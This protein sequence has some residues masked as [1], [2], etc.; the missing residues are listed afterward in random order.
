VISPR[1]SLRN[2]HLLGMLLALP[3]VLAATGSEASFAERSGRGHYAIRALGHLPG[4]EQHV[5]ALALN[6]TGTVVGYQ[7]FPPFDAHAVVWRGDR[8][9]DLSDQLPDPEASSAS[10]VN[11]STQIAG[12]AA[13]YGFL[14]TGRERTLISD[15]YVVRGLNASG[16]V[17]G[18]GEHDVGTA[19]YVW[20]DGVSHDLCPVA[21]CGGS[22]E[23]INDL[24][25]VV[26]TGWVEI[27]DGTEPF[28]W[29]DGVWEELGTLGGCGG[30]ALGVNNL[31]QVVGWADTVDCTGIH[32]F[33]WE[34]GE[35]T[36]LGTIPCCNTS[37][38]TAINDDGV[39]VGYGGY[40]GVESDAFIYRDG[41]MI[42]LDRLL[43]P[44]AGW[45]LINAMDINETGQIV[46]SGFYRG[47][48]NAFVMTPTEH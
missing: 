36:D 25:H 9:Y 6:N 39:I 40:S 34:N 26:G 37:V 5:Q 17:V 30:L 22:G 12:D 29:R 1:V 15:P 16:A 47:R 3:V 38:A 21:D 2:P 19:P 8:V 31:D 42:P 4:G 32:A 14:F 11:D 27:E 33:R 44:G 18:W 28:L 46:G 10:G 13:V 41:R 20:E 48:F 24:G 43:P 23:D 35:M 45:D 7:V